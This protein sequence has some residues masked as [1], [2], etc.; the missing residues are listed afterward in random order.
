MNIVELYL[1]V[2]DYNHSIDIRKWIFNYDE[3]TDRNAVEDFVDGDLTEENFETACR[4]FVSDI[5]D[6]WEQRFYTG[7]VLSKNE[8]ETIKNYKI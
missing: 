7:I 3:E 2:S 5:L 8:Y 6:E 4:G 1:I